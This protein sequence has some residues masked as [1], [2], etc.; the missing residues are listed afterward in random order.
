MCYEHLYKRLQ[1]WLLTQKSTDGNLQTSALCTQRRAD[2]T[3]KETENR[4]FPFFFSHTLNK[5]W[6]ELV[7]QI[8][9]CMQ[10]DRLH[11]SALSLQQIK[12]RC[13]VSDAKAFFFQYCQYHEADHPHGNHQVLTYIR[14]V[15]ELPKQF[16]N[17]V[18]PYERTYLVI[19]AE[20][21]IAHWL[22]TK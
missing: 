21:E 22:W 18:S 10:P 13:G 6:E 9:I 2:R 4:F 3:K 8:S 1:P 19:L 14:M 20:H 12:R 17:N 7:Q 16:L 15:E 11:W 5:Q